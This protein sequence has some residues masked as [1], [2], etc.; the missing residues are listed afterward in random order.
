MAYVALKHLLG[1]LALEATRH[2]EQARWIPV[3]AAYATLATPKHLRVPWSDL[4]PQATVLAAR[5][6]WPM[7]RSNIAPLVDVRLLEDADGAVG[8]SPA[9][10]SSLAYVRQHATRDLELIGQLRPLRVPPTVPDA[11]ACGAILFN[12]GLFFESHEFLEEVWRT[13]P[14]SER[15]LYQGLIQ[16]ATAFYHYEKRN[17][18][19]A[20]TVLAKGLHR[21]APYPGEVLGLRL[22]LLRQQLAPWLEAFSAERSPTGLEGHIPHVEFSD[23]FAASA[24]PP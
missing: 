3:L 13:A 24:N 19:G 6:G 9:F 11:L 22:D 17:W 20:R 18:H 23:R 4:E 14:V 7:T 1:A 8:I 15:D 21:L 10:A 16:V 2:P 12:V 5:F